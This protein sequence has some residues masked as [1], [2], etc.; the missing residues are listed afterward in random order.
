MERNDLNQ[1]YAAF[2]PN[3]E[4]IPPNT[5]AWLYRGLERLAELYEP[6]SHQP[7]AL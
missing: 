7:G 2:E 1:S 3:G 5:L 4:P 6:L